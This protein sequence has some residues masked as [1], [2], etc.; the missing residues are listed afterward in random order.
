MNIR[1]ILIEF[2]SYSS[3]STRSSVTVYI[4]Y[5][6]EQNNIFTNNVIYK[7]S[8]RYILLFNVENEIFKL[9]K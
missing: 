1:Q 2:K 9:R 4:V 3:P 5:I 7:Y 6:N 8:K